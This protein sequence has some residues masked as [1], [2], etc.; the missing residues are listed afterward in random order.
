MKDRQGEQSPPQ[1]R[2]PFISVTLHCVSMTVIVL[3]RSSF[4]FVYLR[5]KSIFF[6]FSW[7]FVLFS[8]YAWYE[9]PVW[10]EY[11]IMC[12]Y[13]LAVITLYFLHLLIAFFRELYRGGEHDHDSGTPHT[14]RL[15]Q[16]LGRT[17]TPLFEKNW[18]IWVE[19]VFVLFSGLTLRLVFGEQHLSFWL[20][21][22]APCLLFKEALNYWF[23]IRQK[24]RHTDSR[25][26]AEDLFGDVPTAP[27]AEAPKPV[28]KAKVKRARASASTAADEIQDRHFEQ[29]LRLMAPYT[30]DDAELN[31]RKLIKQY[32]PDPKQEVDPENSAVSAELNDAIAHFRARLGA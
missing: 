3:M 22:V 10:V 20:V 25:G 30:L 9:K 2:I 15:L 29:V 14:I 6:A 7:A 27:A 19:P 13:G 26:D 17:P 32:H 23:Q 4:G 31:Y 16:M 18:H 8:I 1:T 5:P 11:R 24:K 28:G 12:V 21:I